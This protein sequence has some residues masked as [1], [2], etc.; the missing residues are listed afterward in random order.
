VG[1]ASWAGGDQSSFTSPRSYPAW[2]TS[3][4]DPAIHST[5]S[6]LPIRASKAAIRARPPA[7]AAARERVQVVGVGAQSLD[8][9]LVRAPDVARRLGGLKPVGGPAELRLRGDEPRLEA[10]ERVHARLAEGAAHG[11]VGRAGAAHAPPASA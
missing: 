1:R 10:F 7:R 5:D 2:V 8:E 4:S 6:F 3:S 11:P 9:L